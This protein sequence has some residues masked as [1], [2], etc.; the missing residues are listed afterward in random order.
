[1]NFADIAAGAGIP[2]IRVA[3]PDEVSGA[4]EQ[5]LAEPGPA[6]VEMISD[7]TPCPCHRRSEVR[8]LR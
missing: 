5:T 3:D 4:L 7:P 1:V 6:L 2:A 8:R